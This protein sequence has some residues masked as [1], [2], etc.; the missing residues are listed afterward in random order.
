MFCLSPSRCPLFQLSRGFAPEMLFLS[1][2]RLVPRWHPCPFFLLSPPWLFGLYKV[3]RFPDPLSLLLRCDPFLL[4]KHPAPFSV[5]VF[6]S[7]YQMRRRSQHG[8]LRGSV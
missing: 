2:S 1:P 7:I 8:S 5:L 6:S 3:V 4:P